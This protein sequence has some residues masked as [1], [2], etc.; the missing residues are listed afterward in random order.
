MSDF[1][2]K[3]KEDAKAV[4]AAIDQE[5]TVLEGVP[6][7]DPLADNRDAET[8]DETAED[9]ERVDDDAR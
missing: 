5:L 4:S 7:Y 9:A 8:S 2:R 6:G 3:I 1:I